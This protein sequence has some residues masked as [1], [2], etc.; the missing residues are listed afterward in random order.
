[1]KTALLSH[2]DATKTAG[3]GLKYRRKDYIP[4]DRMPKNVGMFD[5]ATGGRPQ[6]YAW[7]IVVDSAPPKQMRIGPNKS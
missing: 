4:K 1:M 3:R 2:S 5:T 6:A 7:S